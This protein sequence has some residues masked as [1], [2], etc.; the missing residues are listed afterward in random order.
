MDF[1][2]E[3]SP[4]KHPNTHL[5]FGLDN[6]F[7]HQ[8]LHKTNHANHFMTVCLVTYH[9]ACKVLQDVE[10]LQ[11][12]K[13]WKFETS[14]L[15]LGNAFNT[16]LHKSY[17]V[18]TS[19]SSLWGPVKGFTLIDV[20][21]QQQQQQPTNQSTNQPKMDLNNQSGFPTPFSTPLQKKTKKQ[22]QESGRWMG[23]QDCG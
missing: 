8:L 13:H 10:M 3:T 16:N 23:C 19:P 18:P 2:I 22:R 7:Y 12:I 20:L 21:Q 6:M 15:Q 5:Q 14:E 11:R 17:I 1:L 4:I 9:E